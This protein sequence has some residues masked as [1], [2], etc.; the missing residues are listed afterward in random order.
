MMND[1]KNGMGADGFVSNRIFDVLACGAPVISDR[2]AAMPRDLTPW[3]ATWTSGADFPEV[4]AAVLS[5]PPER[6]IERRSFALDMVVTHSLDARA[7]QI[8][9]VMQ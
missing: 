2:V 6:R 7:A 9:E 8:L 4:V 3:V 1:H 5:E